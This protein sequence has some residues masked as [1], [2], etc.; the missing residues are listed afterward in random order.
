M[1][2]GGTLCGIL[3][4]AAGSAAFAAA[5]LPFDLKANE[6]ATLSYAGGRFSVSDIEVHTE[7][8]DIRPAPKD[9][10][11]EG[12]GKRPTIIESIDDTLVFTLWTDPQDG[13]R[14]K[15]T[16]HT[17]KPVIYSAIVIYAGAREVPT[18]I[19]SVQSARS[20]WETWAGPVAALRITGIY[21]AP[22]SEPV[23]G[24]PERGQLARA[25]Q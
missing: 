20:G 10:K 24:Y 9:A 11:T 14:L 17:R 2:V 13:A 12:F 18:T 16:N 8:P 25:P 6:R 22:E 7:Q 19:C 5:Q 3:A 4:L 21:E 23:C 15:I 1:R